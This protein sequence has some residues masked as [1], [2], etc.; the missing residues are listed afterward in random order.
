MLV[1]KNALIDKTGAWEGFFKNL[2]GK[3]FLFSKSDDLWKKKRQATSHAFYKERLVHMLDVLKETLLE[4]QG[5]WLAEIDASTDGMTEIDLSKEVL[6]I[7]Q[8]FLMRIIVGEDIDDQSVEILVRAEGGTFEKKQLTLSDAIEEV[9]IQTLICIAIR[10]FN[11]LWH[12]MYTLTG[13][14]YAF[15]K[16]EKHSNI[17]CASLRAKLFEYVRK[18]KEGLAQSSLG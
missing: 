9:F 1:T 5:K 16:I 10:G 17:N 13:K 12:L 11:P 15:T 8:K 18:R 7:F 14:C 3:S 6:R 4:T 2:F